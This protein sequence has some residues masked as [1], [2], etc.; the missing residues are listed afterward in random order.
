[1]PLWAEALA[2]QLNGK[3]PTLCGGRAIVAA[4]R[5]ILLRFRSPLTSDKKMNRNAFSS[6]KK[7][8]GKKLFLLLRMEKMSSKYGDMTGMRSQKI[9]G[10]PWWWSG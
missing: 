5:F 2:A 3:R 9:A 1:V 6:R 7:R 8:P 4:P 10:L